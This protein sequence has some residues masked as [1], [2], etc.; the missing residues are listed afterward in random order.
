MKSERDSW[1]FAAAAALFYLCFHSY[2]YNF[3]GVACAVAVEL[4]DLR[5]LAHG[6]HVGYGV[7]G[8]AFF[9]LWR[10]LG[11]QG[12]AVVALA[13]LNSLLGGA[14][15]GAFLSALRRAGLGRGR[16]AAAAAGLALSHAYWLWSLE[17]QVYP[18]GLLFMALALREALAER[19]RPARLGALQAAAMLGHVAHAMFA[20]AALYALRRRGGPRWRSSWARYVG[21]GFLVMLAAYALAAAFCIRPS[22]LE[23]V[24]VWLLGSAA[25][26]LDKS[27]SWH[28]SLTPLAVKQWA[29]MSARIFS[30]FAPLAGAPRLLSLGLALSCLGLAAFGAR[31]AWA[32]PRRYEAALCGLWLLP[33]A[34][35][36]LTWEAFTTVYRLSDLLPLWLL[37]GLALQAAPAWAAAALAAA[38]GLVNGFFGIAPHLEPESNPNYLEARGLREAL[39]PGAWIVAASVGQV[40]YPYFGHA[41]PLNMRYWD[42]RLP[43]LAEEL[44][45]MAARGERVFVTRRLLEGAP[46]REWLEG[47]GLAAHERTGLLE[48]KRAGR[49]GSPAA[50]RKRG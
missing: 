8:W 28:G 21:T 40:Y 50:A 25:L 45:R 32:G 29:A 5:H 34:A 44:D 11:Y 9:E 33:Y 13:A 2:Y 15:A 26:T 16:A 1:A 23:D 24:R 42:W 12:E 31:R 17:A 35:L 18:L 38:L 41:K 47:Y 49:K 19:P 30:E 27:F 43:A 22:S 3:D 14:A 46:W 7:L 39:P 48:V 6:N 20:P 37:I 36:F 4:G 10:R